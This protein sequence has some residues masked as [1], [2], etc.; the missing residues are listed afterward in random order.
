MASRSRRTTDTDG[1]NDTTVTQKSNRRGIVNMLK[2]KNARSK[3]IIQKVEWNDLGQPIGKESISLS[4]Y[5]GS[6][7]RRHVPITCDNWRKTDWLNMKEALWD[8]IKETFN[9]I[10]NHKKKLIKRAGELHRQWRTRMRDLA[11]DK[12]GK[13]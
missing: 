3:G 4:H 10:E 6:A 1:T 2:V 7:A 11:K 8:E 12:N 13:K 9:G 5:I